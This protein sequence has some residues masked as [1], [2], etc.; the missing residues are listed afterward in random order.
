M[1]HDNEESDTSGKSDEKVSS[2]DDDSA[3]RSVNEQSDNVEKENE[4]V[5][6]PVRDVVTRVQISKC[7][8]RGTRGGN[9]GARGGTRGASSG[10]REDTPDHNGNQQTIASANN[11]SASNVSRP[12]MQTAEQINSFDANQIVQNVRGM[13]QDMLSQFFFSD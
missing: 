4:S 9:R 13:V 2:G 8:K 1:A 3:S 10:S 11:V 5:F 12:S 7:G 6:S